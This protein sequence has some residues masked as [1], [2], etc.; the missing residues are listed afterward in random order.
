MSA[1]AFG[2]LAQSKGDPARGATKVAT[3]S[4]CHG[5][6]GGAPL[7]G[8]PSLAGQQQEFLELQLILLR[9]GLRDVPSMTGLLKSFSDR[10][11]IDM[12]AYY[13]AVKPLSGGSARDAQ[14][15][16]AG[17]SLS[18]AMGCGSCHMGNYSGQRQVPR[19]VNQREDYLVSA[20]KDYRDNRRSGVDTSMNAVMYKTSDADIAALAYYLAQAGK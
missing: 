12:A 11:L 2:A 14:R 5:A 20:L 9:E 3:C 17:A 15:V 13:S 8:L 7:A 19:I 1:A 10:D 4:A 16:A 6:D 18:A